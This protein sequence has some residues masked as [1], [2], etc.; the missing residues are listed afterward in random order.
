M[1]ARKAPLQTH[2]SMRRAVRCAYV[3][4]IALV[5]TS[6]SLGGAQV[7]TNI[8]SS[9][10]NTQIDQAGNSYNITGGTRPGD[11]P[12]LFHSFGNFSVGDGDI[13][14]FRNDSGLTTSNIFG[15]VT[16]G[17]ISNIYGTLQTTD[18]GNANLFL[19]N[20]SGIILGPGASLNVGGS[21]NLT[22]AQYIRLFDGVHSGNFYANPANDGLANNILTINPSA[23]EFLSASPA[24]YG[25]L[26]APDPNT[27]ITVQGSLLKVPEGRSLS[28]VGGNI[29]IQSDILSDGTTQ[30]A[31]LQAPGGR[32]N[33]VSVASPGEMRLSDFQ[34]APNINGTSFTTMGTVTL[35][36]GATLDVSGQLDALGTPIGKGNGGT[37]LVRGGRL[38]MDASAIVAFTFGAVDGASRAVDIHASQDVALSNSAAI[39][40]GTSLGSGRGGDVV[41]TTPDISLSNFS[42]IATGTSG[43]KSGGDVFLNVG[44]LRLLSGS[45][46]ST[47]T[48]GIDLD[49]DGVTDIF[50][51]RGGNITIRGLRGESSVAGSVMLSG[52]SGITSN[53]AAEGNAGGGDVS[54]TAASVKL[55][56]ASFIRSST[57]S[58]G[59]D[60]NGDGVVD[61]PGRGGNIILNVQQLHAAGGATIT[62]STGFNADGAADGGRITV[63]GL[64]GPGNKTGSVLLSGQGTGIVSDSS[65]GQAGEVTINAGTLTITDGAVISAGSPSSLGPAG[66]VTLTADSILL[67]KDGQIFSRSFARNS[68]PV[69]ITAKELTLDKGS[70]VTSTSS[71]D[72]GRGGDVMI[73][74]GKV[75]LMNGARISSE[76]D[77]FSTGRAGDI[78]MQVSTLNLNSGSQISSA[79]LRTAPLVKTDGTTEPP[80]RAGNITITASG[81]VTSQASTI[82]TSAE[83][84]HGGDISIT[85]H[86][87]RLSNSSVINA[88]TNGPA[89]V[90]RLVLDGN[91]NLV[92]QVVGDGSAGTITI[93]TGSPGGSVSVSGGSIISSSTTGGGNAGQVGITTPA[94]TMDNAII[95]TSTSNT[96]HAG[97]IMAKV[98]RLTM[99]NSSEIS[100]SST[101]TATG[102]AG[103][104]T[105]QG[106]TS[107]ATIVHLTDSSL[108]TSAAHTG[109]GG[110][111][112]VD[113]IN[114]LLNNARISASVKDVLTNEIPS[115]G[116]ANIALSAQSMT[117]NGSRITAESSGSRNAGNILINRPNALGKRF[118]MM[119]S[120]I[121]TS[122]ALADGGNI[123]IY[124]TDAVNLSNSTITSSVGNETIKT[125][126]GGN[127]IIDPDHVILRKSEIRANA[128]AG[129]GGAIDITAN[130]FFAD[131]SSIVDASSTL[132]VSGTVQINAAINN[133]SSVVAQLPESLLAVQAL[134]R[135]SCAARLSE[136]ATSSFVERGRDGIP[137]GPDGLL[138]SPYQPTTASTVKQ[139]QTKPSTKVSGLQL[140]RLFGKERPSSVMV[141]SDHGA[142]SS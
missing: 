15:R 14:N 65:F 105:I 41:I 11:G 87:V 112:S 79:S 2:T 35:K 44:S 31:N 16:G 123:E 50:G 104:L 116:T 129:S 9:G 64:L 66:K 10:L 21:V 51:G 12:N 113:A 117:M 33:L 4:V 18:F 24:A 97:S 118:E 139:G 82:K 70:I 91:G 115:V 69:T 36:E 89:Q 127:I 56:E 95:T 26:T 101:G 57:S 86:N 27:T 8:T 136:G 19:M 100:S 55:D 107:P 71:E 40:V 42:S 47:N 52:G 38:V 92:E 43:Q 90:T 122:A 85:A 59:I 30:A 120:Q 126:Q 58:I 93:A 119:N 94:L 109:Q 5:L 72:G 23:F 78:T 53:T 137:A 106:L 121:N 81:D 39:S 131:A 3:L 84:N 74:G 77:L 128:F 110:R 138:A 75:I 68:G 32:I 108:L 141:F 22:T 45:N 67:A 46:F 130:L 133:L 29:T 13:A 34:P 48:G 140:R 1:D 114:L 25:F 88:S 80:G 102:N 6:P 76:S 99:T 73:Q 63:Q 61:L 142:C 132:G 54:I 83:A 124:T 28:L 60:L 134:L 111:I 125:T 98:G 37:V 17:N 20:P 49:G 135:A 96:G 62:S 7:A 103:S